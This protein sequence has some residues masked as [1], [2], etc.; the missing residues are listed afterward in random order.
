MDTRPLPDEP[1]AR[2]RAA[3]RDIESWLGVLAGDGLTD[4]DRNTA[5]HYLIVAARDRRQAR[6]QIAQVGM[7]I[8]YG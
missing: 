8:E 1:H 3:E 4:A 6:E 7:A 5:M 2:L